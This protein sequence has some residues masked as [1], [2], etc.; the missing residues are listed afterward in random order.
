MGVLALSTQTAGV[1][2]GFKWLQEI[3]PKPL[4]V[5]GLALNSLLKGPV[6]PPVCFRQSLGVGPVCTGSGGPGQGW[7]GSGILRQRS[8]SQQLLRQRSCSQ[9]L[10]GSCR[11]WPSPGLCTCPCSR[12]LGRCV[13]LAARPSFPAAMALPAATSVAG[14]HSPPS[15]ASLAGQR[16]VHGVRCHQGGHH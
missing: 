9:Q 16:G 4:C 14:T 8:F 10:V 1:H 13:S 15:A 7:C 2:R 12:A 11:G 3:L 5:L 6:I